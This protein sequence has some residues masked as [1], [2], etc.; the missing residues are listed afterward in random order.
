MTH[1]RTTRFWLLTG[2]ALMTAGT[3]HAQSKPTPPYASA[4]TMVQAA[5]GF[6]SI[7]AEQI[8]RDTTEEVN[9]RTGQRELVAAPFDPFEQDPTVA[10]SVR[11][12]SVDQATAIDGTPLRDGALLEMD[13]Y[14]NSPSDDPY[15]GRGYGDALFLNGELAP[16][17]T[18]DSRILECSSRVEN[19][20]YDHTAYYGGPSIGIYRPYRHYA[21]HYGFANSGFG[22]GFG[23]RGYRDR[24]YGFGYSSRGY[25]QPRLRNRNLRRD[26]RELRRE[27]RDRDDRQDARRDRERSERIKRDADRRNL[28]RV[29]SY[30]G[31]SGTRGG[32]QR[33]VNP[34]RRL[35]MGTR[36]RSDRDV[37]RRSEPRQTDTRRSEPRRAAPER[38][39]RRQP[40]TR[41]NAPRRS[42]TRRETA[43][44]PQRAEPRRAEPRRQSN[45]SP[46][47]A[48]PQRAQPAP[49]SSTPP[50][51]TRSAPP[52]T[53]RSTPRRQSNP[54]RTVRRQLD[55]FPRDGYG[56][57]E[58]VTS[59][60]VDCAREETLRVFLPA[61]RLDAARF[62]GLTVLVLDR[63][64]GE[65]PVFIPP[66][67]IEGFRLAAS[68][69]IRP[70]GV[71]PNAQNGTLTRVPQRQGNT[72]RLP[73][74]QIESAPCPVGTTLQ[75]DG[76]CLQGSVI[77]SGSSGYPGR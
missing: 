43:P 45:P 74:T 35:E 36:T 42:E 39:E 53:T 8:A 33:G 26:N 72:Y 57:R 49:R 5:P 27:I 10:A 12:R 34:P 29:D 4:P 51:R 40:E 41:R 56:G 15:G 7:P 1:F 19:V 2:A 46:R 17:V 60:S 77:N 67:Y 32:A 55:F 52:K 75:A 28:G 76:T 68:G 25:S 20:V 66:N 14:Y 37:V 24:G 16:V 65:T 70:Q 54:G 61:D 48:A 69:Q 31:R 63:D 71:N 50:K 11:L 64:G 23:S 47:R 59:R 44:Q 22:F 18:R 21:G 30:S 62:D 6:P 58:V 3:V 13:I 38:A 73:D 9:P